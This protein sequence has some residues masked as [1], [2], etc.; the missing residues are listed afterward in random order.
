TPPPS[1]SSGPT[2][3]PTRLPRI[4]KKF[5]P[6]LPHATVAPAFFA[7]TH[8]FCRPHLSN[9]GHQPIDGVEFSSQH[10]LAPPLH[11]TF[12][13]KC[14][15]PKSSTAVTNPIAIAPKS[16]PLPGAPIGKLAA[17]TPTAPDFAGLI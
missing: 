12:L 3:R 5:L 7:P 14:V 15:H 1:S 13:T 16:A 2:R 8:P 9:T 10:H 17:S 11:E 4:P 6:H